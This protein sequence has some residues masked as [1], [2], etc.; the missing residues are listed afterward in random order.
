VHARFTHACVSGMELSRLVRLFSTS[1]NW[2]NATVNASNALGLLM[3]ADRVRL[4]KEE[5]RIKSAVAM[6]THKAATAAT[7]TTGQTSEREAAYVRTIQ[8]ATALSGVRQMSVTL[9]AATTDT[10]MSLWLDHLKQSSYQQA[11]RV[12]RQLAQDVNA[13]E[14]GVI[15]GR[16]GLMMHD[17]RHSRACSGCRPLPPRAP[18]VTTPPPPFCWPSATRSRGPW[19]NRCT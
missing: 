10:G 6:V 11:N 15:L 1:D 3:G 13:L 16:S 5:D 2:Q 8:A 17:L 18:P 14:T 9:A 19:W 7:S 4:A 12:L